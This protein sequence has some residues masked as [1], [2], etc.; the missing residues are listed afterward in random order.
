MAR[1]KSAGVDVPGRGEHR[2][3]GVVDPDIDRSEF[4]PRRGPAA[5]S[6][7][8]NWLTS[9]AR[10]RARPPA[11]VTSRG[12][13]LQARLAAGQQG[14]VEP[15]LGE[16]AGRGPADARRRPGDHCYP[17]CCHVVS[18]LWLLVS[19]RVPQV[20][21]AVLH[22]GRRPARRRPAWRRAAA[23]ASAAVRQRR[24]TAPSSTMLAA[25]AASARRPAS[26]WYGSG[27]ARSARPGSGAGPPSTPTTGAAG[28][29]RGPARR[30]RSHS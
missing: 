25:W 3:H 30:T 29:G 22:R 2:G 12:R 15:V 27:G 17:A 1:W 20:G 16:G 10:T 4:G 5:A 14:H 13:G 26:A 8:S 9:A 18:F 24:D 21:L 11:A 19:L 28:H 6:T 7:W 23:S